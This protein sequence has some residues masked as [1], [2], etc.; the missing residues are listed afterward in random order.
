[1]I[2][3]VLMTCALLVTIGCQQ[4]EENSVSLSGWVTSP[5]ED[6]LVRTIVERYEQTDDAFSVQYNPIQANYIEKIQLMLGTGTAPDVFMLEAFWAP[7]LIGYDTLL[8]LNSFIDSS[9]DFGIE[10]FE[11]ALL[12]A[13]TEDG[14]IYVIPKDYS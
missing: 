7:S 2:R 3:T 13:F 6:E 10:D 14:M 1:M 5:Q 4:T 12:E 9:D 8:P 11:P